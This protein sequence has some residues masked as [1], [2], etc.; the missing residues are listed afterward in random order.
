MDW[1]SPAAT[2]MPSTAS[3]TTAEGRAW[4]KAGK[5]TQKSAV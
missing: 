5:D 3:A 1:R 2:D 4:K